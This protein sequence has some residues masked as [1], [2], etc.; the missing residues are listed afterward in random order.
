[1]ST[2]T[3]M[4]NVYNPLTGRYIA[5]DGPTA[6]KL[7]LGGVLCLPTPI[8]KRHSYLVR[9]PKEILTLI[10]SF[11]PPP[12]RWL[13]A[14]HDSRA[15]KLAHKPNIIETMNYCVNHTLL[16][17]VEWFY[18]WGVPL[19][20]QHLYDLINSGSYEAACFS[21]GCHPDNTPTS[22]PQLE[23]MKLH[24]A[25]IGGGT[26]SSMVLH[27]EKQGWKKSKNWVE[28]A[29][30]VDRVENLSPSVLLSSED[31]RKEEY[32]R[33]CCVYGSWKVLGLMKELFNERKYL[34]II[35]RCIEQK[36]T[37]ELEKLLYS[38]GS[39]ILHQLLSLQH[40]YR[41]YWLIKILITTI[42]KYPG[43]DGMVKHSGIHPLIDNEEAIKVFIACK[44]TP[45]IE[46]YNSVVWNNVDA[47]LYL[48]YKQWK[49]PGMGTL[50]V[51]VLD[52]LINTEVVLTEWSLVGKDHELLV[53]ILKQE[54]EILEV[55]KS[56]YLFID[57]VKDYIKSLYPM[58]QEYIRKCLL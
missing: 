33:L 27:L 52:P 43:K 21:F 57:L 4:T 31:K 51:L 37:Q 32:F 18:H 28:E 34:I 54:K 14:L 55:D 40:N 9:L 26:H 25:F 58:E 6:K 41:F 16:V 46:C 49:L 24:R 30:K 39:N 36:N 19:T 44:I 48:A 45:C 8:P 20:S 13:I 38:L 56:R 1:M 11:I 53:W 3:Q 12:L 42:Q 10:V 17:L 23:L 22:I 5:R 35:N 29:I 7:L 2:I 50:R 15:F 47:D